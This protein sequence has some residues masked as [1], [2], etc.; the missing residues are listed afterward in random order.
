MGPLYSVQVFLW[1]CHSMACN[2]DVSKTGEIPKLEVEPTSLSL[3]GLFVGFCTWQKASNDPIVSNTLLIKPFSISL[4]LK[5]TDIKANIKA[6]IV[7]V[8]LR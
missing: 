6:Y 1:F 3:S 2:S 7:L 4:G 5:F 8:F